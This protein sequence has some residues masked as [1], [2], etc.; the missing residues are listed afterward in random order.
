MDGTFAP[1]QVADMT[2]ADI[3]RILS[4]CRTIALVGW[5]AKP[6]RPSHAVAAFL[7]ARGYRVIPVNPGLEGQVAP[8]GEAVRGN[9][10]QVGA[11]DMVDVFRRSEDV[12]QV[13]DDVLAMEPRPRVL[14][15]QLGVWD[16]ASADRA[17]ASGMEVV[18]DRCPKIE[19]Q[20]LGLPPLA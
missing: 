17:R 13:V 20:R 10:A 18:E 4:E 8:W 9:L 15:L 14:W 7:A 6:D 12:G 11:V 16:A 1:W 2:D 19:I 5:S 3:P